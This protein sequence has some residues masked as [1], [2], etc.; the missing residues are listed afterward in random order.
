MVNLSQVGSVNLRGRTWG[1]VRYAWMRDL[2]EG[3]TMV[4]YAVVLGT[5]DMVDAIPETLSGI[6]DLGKYVG[7]RGKDL[8]SG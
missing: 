8:M 6:R 5:A 2:F 7:M 1:E 3:L 4:T